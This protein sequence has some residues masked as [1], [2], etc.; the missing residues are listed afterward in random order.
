[1]RVPRT[2]IVLVML[3]CASVTRAA[4]ES[5]QLMLDT[6]GH[7]GI[8]QGLVFTPDGQQV[9]STGD[10]KF[11]RVWDLR[12][13]KTVRTI[14]GQTGPGDEGKIYAMAFSPDG[15]W[16]AVGGFFARSQHPDDKAIGAIRLYDFATGELNKLLKE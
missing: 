15:R 16:L 10:D 4:E 13:G 2:A 7:I 8:L 12:S 6:G 3:A 11:I 14:R 5:L 9:V 1:M